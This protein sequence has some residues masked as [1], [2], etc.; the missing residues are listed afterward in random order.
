MQDAGKLSRLASCILP[1]A[2][3]LLFYFYPL[4]SILSLSLAPDGTLDLSTLENLVQTP[5]YLR[6]LWFTLWQALIST[7]LTV[8]LALP[9]A[10]VFARFEFP[11]KSLVQALTT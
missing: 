1:L 8:G 9:G 2:F 7:L 6:I 4:T 5:R 3:L 10:Y 11:G